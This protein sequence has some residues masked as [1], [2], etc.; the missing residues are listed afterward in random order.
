VLLQDTKIVA[1][2]GE[3]DFSPI[4]AS[5]GAHRCK[6][7]RQGTMIARFL[8]CDGAVP[9]SDSATRRPSPASGKRRIGLEEKCKTALAL[10]PIPTAMTPISQ[11]CD[12]VIQEPVC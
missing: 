2:G 11:E 8:C 1:K 3:R 10:Q 6:R 4:G 9:L 5:G 7:G 12:Y